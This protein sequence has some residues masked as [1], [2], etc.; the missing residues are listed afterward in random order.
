MADSMASAAWMSPMWVKAWGKL[1]SS[2]PGGRVDLLGEQADVVGAAGHQREQR[3]RPLG[4]ARERE[5]LGEPER[6]DAER[7]LAAG[8][9][10]LV[11]VAVDEPAFVGEVRRDR[12]D[13]GAHAGIVGGEEADDAASSSTDAS[14][15]SRPN[16]CVNA[17]TA[18]LQPCVED[19]GADQIAFVA[20]LRDALRRTHRTAARA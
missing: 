2:S 5:A 11:Q 4:L 7:A 17:P 10:V 12:L 6:A 20:P 3:A 16:A 18:S 1:P 13:R 15:S 19:R 9:P 14:S 8:Q